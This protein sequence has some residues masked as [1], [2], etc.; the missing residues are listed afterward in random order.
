MNKSVS[1]AEFQKVMSLVI[2][3]L[4][5]EGEGAVFG[6][7][8]V[9]TAAGGPSVIN[10]GLKTSVVLDLA[11]GQ[12]VLACFLPSPDGVPHLAKGMVSA[13]EVTAAPED[14]VDV[15]EQVASVT[16]KVFSFTG[17]PSKLKAGENTIRVVHAG[18]EPHEMAVVKLNGITVEQVGEMLSGPPPAGAPAG[19]PPFEFVGGYQAIMPGDSGWAVLDL[20]AGEYGLI[21]LIPSPANQFKPHFALGML[22][23][24]TVE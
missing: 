15:P 22:A 13:L 5:T 23:S 4:P 3:A 21:C 7:F 14:A 8:Q 18:E 24:I 9:S 11:E 10:P 2:E 12:Y 6:N 1:Q 17:V 20:E 19:P 16:L